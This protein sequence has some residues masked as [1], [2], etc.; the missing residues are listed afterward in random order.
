MCRGE[1][2]DGV[3]HVASVARI[4]RTRSM[5]NGSVNTIFQSR[6]G[7]CMALLP[8][9]RYEAGEGRF[10]LLPF[11]FFL[12]RSAGFPLASMV[13]RSATATQ[14]PTAQVLK[15]R[16][17]AWNEHDLANFASASCFSFPYGHAHQRSR[18]SRTKLPASWILVFLKFRCLG[19]SRYVRSS[20]TSTLGKARATERFD[21]THSC[22]TFFETALGG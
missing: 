18:G 17:G 14:G 21:F 11:Y 6:V 3:P 8:S 4:S 22:P 7:L 1:R 15:T 20:G 16:C 2:R 19:L 13:A 10:I 5:A 9:T 12:S